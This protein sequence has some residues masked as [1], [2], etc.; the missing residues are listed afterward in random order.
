MVKKALILP[1][2]MTIRTGHLKEYY[3]QFEEVQQYF[4]RASA[5]LE[6]NLYKS[7]FSEDEKLINESY[8][9]R[10]GIVS[11]T[12]GLLEKLNIDLKNYSFISGPSL[13]SITSGYISGAYS[14]ET[15]L[16]MIVA[17]VNSEKSVY[18][19]DKYGNYMFYNIRQEELLKIIEEMNDQG[20]YVAPCM[21]TAD[22]QMIIT[23]ELT[24][25]EKMGWKV[26]KNGGLGVHIPYSP[27]AHSSMMNR[28]RDIFK[29]K[30]MD[31]NDFKDPI[32]PNIC[33]NTAQPLLK[34]EQIKES[35]TEQYVLPVRWTDILHLL[36]KEEIKQLDIIGPGKFLVKSMEYTDISFDIE[37]YLDIN[38][39]QFSRS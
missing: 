2:Q 33:N 5:I 11:I 14:F 27:P 1:P 9:G 35:L 15:A 21:Y 22:N 39:F 32:I 18:S 30:F 20:Y 4:E 34:G 13:G 25:L 29:Q 12:C 36:K 10:C 8:I 28:V 19:D 26:L 17:M 6:I 7:F 3:E 31:I 24:G 37:S 38:D 23:G 16:K